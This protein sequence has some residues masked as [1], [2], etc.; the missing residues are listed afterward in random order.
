MF[1]ETAMILRKSTRKA[2]R[3]KGCLFWRVPDS[4]REYVRVVVGVVPCNINVVNFYSGDFY[5]MRKSG[6]EKKNQA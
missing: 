1:A 4:V 6:N 3:Q 5:G 2:F